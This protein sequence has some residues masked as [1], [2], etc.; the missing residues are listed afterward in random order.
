MKLLRLVCLSALFAALWCALGEA[1]RYTIDATYLPESRALAMKAE[2]VYT[3]TTGE[4]LSGVTFALPANCFRRV[5][6]LPYDGDTLEKAFP[7]GYA[8][9]GAQ[10]ERVEFDSSRAGYGFLQ[11]G[12][13]YFT[14]KAALE[15]G[16]TG[17]F[18]FEYTLLLSDNKAFLG[19]GEDVR[20]SLFYP[21]A[22]P[23]RDG[24]AVTYP[25]SVCAHDVFACPADHFMTLRVPASYSA[26]CGGEW[27]RSEIGGQAVYSVSL[28][29]ASHLSLVLSKRFY[30][31]TGESAL[32]T[33]L[34]V[35]GSNR[36]ACRGALK[37]L[38]RALDV[39]E[40]R[41]GKAPWDIALT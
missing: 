3:N 24:E 36:S 28:K 40:A 11:G 12:D 25:L 31:Y 1:D 10:F 21:I 34:S 32:G 19:C 14:V 8:P 17:T 16:Q 29:D 15:P 2:T 35:Y 20:L 39:Y 13:V 23:V 37:L 38:T 22:C 30:E 7:W 27:E 33:R 41:L 6:A 5:S 18:R 9:A 26:A 4:R